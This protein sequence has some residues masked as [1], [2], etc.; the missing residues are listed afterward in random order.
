MRCEGVPQTVAVRTLHDPGRVHCFFN[1][2]LQNSFGHVMSLFVAAARID[3][4]ARGREN[5]LPG[6][7][8]RRVRRFSTQSKWQVHGTESVFEILLMLCLRAQRWRRNGS[9]KLSGNIVTRSLPP[10]ASRTVICDSAKSMS[11]TRR[12]THSINRNPLP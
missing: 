12:R 6:P 2:T 7:F 10:F 1:R 8:A 5:I 9:D 4:N 11:L 3:S